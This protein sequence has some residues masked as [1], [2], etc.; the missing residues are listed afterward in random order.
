MTPMRAKHCLTCIMIWQ[1]KLA[2]RREARTVSTPA[3]VLAKFG[4]KH[5]R[6]FVLG[7]CVNFHP[8]HFP[9]LSLLWKGLQG[10]TLARQDRL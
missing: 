1:P 2:G 8:L 10:A 5:R 7:K 4:C 6:L 3:E 9:L